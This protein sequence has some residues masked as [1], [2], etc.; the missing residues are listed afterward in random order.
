MNFGSY[1]LVKN[2]RCCVIVM[3]SPSQCSQLVCVYIIAVRQSGQQAADGLN[4]TPPD[5]PEIRFV[6]S[7]QDS[8]ETQWNQRIPAVYSNY[9]APTIQLHN[10]HCERSLISPLHKRWPTSPVTCLS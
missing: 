9:A 10:K 8:A 4:Y 7:K 6:R 3:G 2:K 1:G 5:S